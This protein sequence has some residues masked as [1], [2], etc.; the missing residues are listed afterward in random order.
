M[1]FILLGLNFNLF[2]QEIISQTDYNM[3]VE[4]SNAGWDKIDS[5]DYNNAIIDFNKSLKLNSG[6][7]EAYVGRANAYHKLKKYKEAEADIKR[8]LVISKNESDINYLAGNIFIKQEK[9]KEAIFYYTNALENN[10]SSGVQID[11]YNCH[12]NRGNAYL[13]SEKYS[14]AIQDF[15]ITLSAKGTFANAYHNRGIAY[16]HLN[17]KQD[18]CNDFAAAVHY[19]SDKTNFY[20]NQY[21][22]GVKTQKIE[23]LK[24]DKLIS[25][26]N[27]LDIK[28]DY[29]LLLKDTLYYNDNWQ[30]CNSKVYN[31][32]R[33][34]TVNS[35][36]LFFVNEFRDYYQSDSLLLEGYYN[37]QG[38]KNGLF[39]RYYP[40][41]VLYS[42]GAY[43][44]NIMTGIWEFYYENGHLNER[45][46]FTKNDFSILES[47]NDDL[48]E[49]V[50]DGTGVWTKYFPLS[51]G[52]NMVLKA[53]FENENR[54]GKWT[55][56]SSNKHLVLSEVYKENRFH[57]GKVY[58][59]NSSSNTGEAIKKSQIKKGLF[60]PVSYENIEAFDYS[61][62]TYKSDYPY[63]SKLR[64]N[65][66]L[67]QREDKFNG[68][69]YAEIF[70][71]VEDQPI[72]PGGMGAFYKYVGMNIKYPNDA[73][74]MG[75]QGKVFVQFVVDKDGS[76]INVKSIKGIGAGCDEEAV[77]IIEAAPN[78]K[79]GKQRGK[80]VKVRM[81]LPI[82]FKLG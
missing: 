44:K 26:S 71:I 11:V 69:I 8:A 18:A 75:V 4:I 22:K 77:R 64:L 57:N 45:V 27:R 34:A 39:Q 36:E 70:D 76:L 60:Y 82:T 66:S 33:V 72:P 53:K 47:F 61:L 3:S 79:P 37:E 1:I 21:C 51:N 55:L 50:I 31:F 62:F 56:K 5:Q 19:G 9:Y 43:E 41:G 80:P 10:E 54:V 16:R 49:G 28:A 73:R 42:A 6:Y 78:W 48:S 32:Y 35:K 74:R 13:F 68:D 23:L 25:N 38:E 15:S 2:A 20:V 67:Y 29:P 59:Q 14:Q 24:Q 58:T 52:E 12:F 30:L 7:T 81:I 17:K 46:K 65:E 40:N 63:I